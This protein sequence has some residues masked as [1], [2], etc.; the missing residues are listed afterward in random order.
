[1]KILLSYFFLLFFLL[2]AEAQLGPNPGGTPGG[3][4]GQL[5]YNSS[6][7]FGGYGIGSGL[8]V[9]GGNLTAPSDPSPAIVAPATIRQIGS[10][11]SMQNAI[12]GSNTEAGYRDWETFPVPVSALEI[13]DANWYV[14]SGSGETTTGG[15]KTVRWYV[16]Y[17]H[18]TW[19]TITYNSTTTAPLGVIPAGATGC[20][21]YT[22]LGFTIPAYT[23]IRITGDQ[24]MGS[25]G[26]VTEETWSNACDRANGDEYALGAG[27]YGNGQNDTVLGPNNGDL[28]CYHPALV[29]ALSDRAVWALNA[30]SIGEGTNDVGG[31]P[32]G[33]RG[34]YMRA[35]L[36]LGGSAINVSAAGDQAVLYANTSNSALRTALIALGDATSELLALGV[37]DFYSASQT[38]DQVITSRNTITANIKTAVPG[39]HVFWTTVTPDTNSTDGGATTA[40]QTPNA[41]NGGAAN[42]NRFEFNDFIR[43]LGTYSFT[44]T[45]CVLNSTTA[46][47]GCAG[48]APTTVAAGMLVTGTNIPALDTI[49]KTST[50]NVTT[51][52]FTL[53]AAATGAPTETLTFAWPTFTSTFP[54][55]ADGVVDVARLVEGSPTMIAGVQANG[56]VWLPGYCG[57]IDCLHPNTFASTAIEPMLL[58]LLAGQR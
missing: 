2:P 45:S 39:I 46:I 18:G 37:N 13:C 52:A 14:P 1:M 5:Q 9:T 28:N 11:V 49:A 26:H 17:P 23:K 36:A 58:N 42:V 51:G 41:G 32:G 44:G 10:R 6:G 33:G 50:V 40:N 12:S 53:T 35:L 29:M 43:G 25:G 31:D 48:L 54:T 34:L 55:S 38:A 57:P 8:V 30:D 7:V 16:E 3:S 22:Q 4:S 47:T 15:A 20:S 21:D 27:G 56:G 24:I 19:T